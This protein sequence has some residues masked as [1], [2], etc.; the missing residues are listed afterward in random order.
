MHCLAGLDT[1]TSGHV[2]VRT[3]DGEIDLGA[4]NDRQLTRVRREQ[5]GFVFQAFNL[6]PTLSAKENILLPMTLAGT[7]PDKTWVELVID[8]VGLDRRL[9]H[10][11][12]ELSGGQQQ[13]V[14]VARALA[15]KPAL[16]FADE[17]TGN[18]DS[19][20]GTEILAFMRHAVDAL[21]QTIVM[22]THDA[23][24]AS[25]ADTVLVPR[26][27]SD[28]RLDGPPV[29][30]PR[31]RPDEAVRRSVGMSTLI[32]HSLWSRKR[33]LLATCTAVV[34]GVA[35]LAATMIFG[36][37][38]KAGFRNAF[39]SANAGTDVVVRSADRIGSAEDRVTGVIDASTVEA[40]ARVEGVA[41]AVPYV[42]GV[43]QIVGTD[44]KPL[45][46]DGPP[47]VAA[48]WVADRALSSFQLAEGR[49]PEPGA[50]IEVVIDRASAAARQ[51]AR[52]RPHVRAH[53]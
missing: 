25:H 16:I 8:T 34:L 11:P 43:A 47:A 26:R 33:R 42:E 21:G 40:V 2:F 35:F 44:G 29:G 13:R 32:L 18:L 45:G 5:I 38:A 28:R 41:L 31:A 12:S 9:A 46:G 22:V 15:S 19:Q 4:L 20:T 10:R 14:A 27:R 24:A 53:A 36:D 52:R 6:L 51:P 49:P 23:V 17:P 37:T 39:T 3:A 48:S 1:L 7:R 30:R 50:A